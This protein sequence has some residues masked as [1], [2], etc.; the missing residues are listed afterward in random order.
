[1]SEGTKYSHQLTEADVRRIVQ[2]ELRKLFPLPV[3]VSPQPF[4]HIYRSYVKAQIDRLK[5]PD[6][7]IEFEYAPMLKIRSVHGETN[8]L[9]LDRT[10]LDLIIL[11]LYGLADRKFNLEMIEEYLSNPNAE[12]LHNGGSEDEVYYV[13][14]KPGQTLRH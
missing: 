10:A 11:A 1:M 8:Y 13:D 9:N 5:G 6:G 3:P 7:K 14:R 12:F 2:E 4:E